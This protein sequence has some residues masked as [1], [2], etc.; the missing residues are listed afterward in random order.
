[1]RAA[2]P[3]TMETARKWVAAAS[4]VKVEDAVMVR[5]TSVAAPPVA[6]H[7]MLVVPKRLH[8]TVAALLPLVLFPLSMSMRMNIL[9]RTSGDGELDGRRPFNECIWLVE[10]TC[11]GIATSRTRNQICRLRASSL[12]VRQLV[13]TPSF[14][15]GKLTARG[16]ATTG[17]VGAK[18]FCDCCASAAPRKVIKE[19]LETN[20]IFAHKQNEGQEKVV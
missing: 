1:M 16:Y 7:A 2:V 10:V 8:P 5:P 3:V 19:R 9:R 20:N 12:C 4:P 6:E 11:T 14:F 18:R 15:P 13:L 17:K